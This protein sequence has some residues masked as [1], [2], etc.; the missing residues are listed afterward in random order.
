MEISA[1]Q[2]G[3]QDLYDTEVKLPPPRR[4]RN[5]VSHV[6]IHLVFST[7]AHTLNSTL[8][9]GAPCNASFETFVACKRARH[10]E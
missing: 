10:V 8:P 6:A 9:T 3:N 4:G 1:G 5:K 7:F 2:G